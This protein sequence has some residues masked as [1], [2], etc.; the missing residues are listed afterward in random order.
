MPR[1]KGRERL[2]LLTPKYAK[3]A[4]DYDPETG[5]FR[6][7]VRPLHHFPD[8]RSMKS[9]NAR[10]AGTQAGRRRNSAN[11]SGPTI[12]IGGVAVSAGKLAWYMSTGDMPELVLYADGDEYNTTL[13]NLT[14]STMHKKKTAV[15]RFRPAPHGVAGFLGV[16][17]RRGKW[18]A[19]LGSSR[20]H[21]VDLG[22]FE[23][24]EDAIAARIAAE[25][26]Y[27][28]ASEV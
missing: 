27:G 17:A 21:R 20:G 22:Y 8:E 11:K 5:V 14:A 13:R 12:R 19:Q 10:F 24:K 9:H 18:H 25:K 23:R 16:T 15:A 4:L 26:K 28:Y 6:W 1:L 3:E 2:Q 7:R